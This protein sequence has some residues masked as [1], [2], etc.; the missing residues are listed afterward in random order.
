MTAMDSKKKKLIL[1]IAGSAA[2][3]LLI[4]ALLVLLLGGG[5]ELPVN[6]ERVSTITG[7]TGGLTNRFA[8]VVEPQEKLELKLDNSR[9]LEETHVSEGD[10]V[11][12]GDKLFTYSVEELEL[13]VEQMQLDIERIE[14]SIKTLNTQIS[15]LTRERDRITS[16][17]LKLEYSQQIQ[18]YEA[19][20]KQEEYNK[21]L[22][23]L[24]VDRVVAKI[25]NSTVFAEMS[26]VVQS[27]G[28]EGYSDGA[29]GVYITIIADGSYRVRGEINEQN[30]KELELGAEVLIRSRLNEEETWVGYIDYIDM[31]NPVSGG[32]TGYYFQTD[33]VNSSTKY[34]FHVELT[35]GNGLMLGQHVYIEPYLETD[36]EGLWLMEYYIT[37]SGSMDNN[38]WVWAVNQDRDRLEKRDITLGKYDEA[39][40]RYEITS[41]LAP[42][43]ELAWPAENLR[44][45]MKVTR[46]GFTASPG[47]E[48]IVD[49]VD[50]VEPPAEP[51]EQRDPEGIYDGTG[52]LIGGAEPVGAAM[53]PLAPAGGLTW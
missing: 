25:A 7:M 12:R 1:I 22:K 50:S 48:P 4:I 29:T 9:K 28:Q 24:E 10:Y 35:D 36:S 14:N 23:E 51:T 3:V 15:T 39:T 8:G 33:S 5:G 49:G 43:D 20:A 40:R 38:A 18:S 32:E 52:A 47:D 19:Q 46:S 16:E 27:L 34:P 41:G 6:V 45:G 31:E 44:S 11:V 13:S 21:K 42:T 26:G 53:L 30:I 2:A 37:R 17:S